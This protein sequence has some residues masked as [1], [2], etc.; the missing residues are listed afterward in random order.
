MLP[1]CV[2]VLNVDVHVYGKQCGVWSFVV[3]VSVTHW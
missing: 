3:G 1:A 2:D